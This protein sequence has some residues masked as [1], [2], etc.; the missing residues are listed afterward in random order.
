MLTTTDGLVLV[1][2]DSTRAGCS[3]IPQ[4][5]C[6]ARDGGKDDDDTEIAALFACSNA[7]IDD[8]AT[9]GIEDRTLLVA[10]GSD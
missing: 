2:H 10:R 8:R 7:S 9:D 6:K 1:V 3:R 5:A 4:V